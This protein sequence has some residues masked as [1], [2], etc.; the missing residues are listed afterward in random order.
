MRWMDNP[1]ATAQR[2]AQFLADFPVYYTSGEHFRTDIVRNILRQATRQLAAQGPIAFDWQA[3]DALHKA[4]KDP[5]KARAP[6]SQAARCARSAMLPKAGDPFSVEVPSNLTLMETDFDLYQRH[7]TWVYV[8]GDDGKLVG[9]S[10][11]LDNNFA[12][13][14]SN[15]R[16]YNAG[17][18]NVRYEEQL[19]DDNNDRPSS[20][21]CA[22]SPTRSPKA[23]RS[24]LSPTSQPPTATWSS[25]PSPHWC[26]RN[27]PSCARLPAG[28]PGT[29]GTHH[30]DDR[31]YVDE[32]DRP[33]RHI[34]KSRQYQ[35]DYWVLRA[36]ELHEAE[37][38]VMVPDKTADFTNA[39]WAR[40]KEVLGKA[41]GPVKLPTL[42]ITKKDALEVKWWN[43]YWM[44]RRY[45]AYL[46]LSVRRFYDRNGIKK[47]VVVYRP[48]KI[49]KS[50]KDE[51]G[52]SKDMVRRNKAGWAIVDD[53]DLHQLCHADHQLPQYDWDGN[54]TGYSNYRQAP[55]AFRG[56]LPEK[57]TTPLTAE[58]IK[59]L[60]R[61]NIKP[62]RAVRPHRRLDPQAASRGTTTAQ[63][64]NSFALALALVRSNKTF[65]R[66]METISRWEYEKDHRFEHKTLKNATQD[67]KGSK[68]YHED[69][70][71][72]SNGRFDSNDAILDATYEEFAE[73]TMY[74]RAHGTGST[75]SPTARSRSPPQ[76][77]WPAWKA[78]SPGGSRNPRSRMCWTSSCAS[79]KR[80]TRRKTTCAGQSRSSRSSPC[81]SAIR[82]W[83]RT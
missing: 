42:P 24:R 37:G 51:E 12:K 7:E 61:E 77:S 64:R 13:L 10:L 3:Y 22:S 18:Y 36:Q 79:C 62:I 32:Y 50:T 68:N 66:T 34:W 65:Q 57:F 70:G 2:I 74:A 56:D 16:T 11:N 31:D 81:S 14:K 21:R 76:P 80:T 35:H 15:N 69:E 4:Q 55:P 63:I 78:S 54:I 27:R 43:L 9:L 60:G 44:P 5:D 71:E 46:V 25:R 17:K 73:A 58:E 26:P 20:A 47:H 23:A 38:P 6:R 30:M 40:R 67:L 45:I 8:A 39:Y 83:K 49:I 53:S 48:V 1:Q 52:N 33:T 75:C 59:T 19:A 41:E 82:S 72:L 28:P 29:S